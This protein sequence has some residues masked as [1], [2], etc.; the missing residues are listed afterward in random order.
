MKGH[1]QSLETDAIK[2]S[3]DRAQLPLLILQWKYQ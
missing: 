2:K 3:K 1:N